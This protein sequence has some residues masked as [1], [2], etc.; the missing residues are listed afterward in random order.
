MAQTHAY[1]IV[2]QHM[3]QRNNSIRKASFITISLYST[4][5]LVASHSRQVKR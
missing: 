3:K 5:L 2:E 4:T 1:P